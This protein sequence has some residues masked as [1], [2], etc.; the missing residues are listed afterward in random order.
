LHYFVVTDNKSF[1]KESFEIS[2]A[3]YQKLDESKNILLDALKAEDIYDQIVESYWDYKSKVNYWNIRSVSGR[4][5]DYSINHEIRSSLNRLAFNV[6][7]LGKLY[8]DLHYYEDKQNFFAFDITNDEQAK[9]AVIEQR[10]KIFSENV[11]YQIGC[12]LRSYSQHSSLPVSNFTTGIHNV[13]NTIFAS[14]KIIYGY[15]DLVGAKVPKS[16]IN[17][18]QKFDLTEILDGYVFAIAQMHAL[19]RSLIS[20]TVNK[21]KNTI[22]AIS[23][24]YYDESIFND[25]SGQVHLESGEKYYADLDWFGVVD[26]LHKKHMFTINYTE[27]SFDKQSSSVV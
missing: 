7:N 18:D 12:K 9:L 2:N 17:E 20:E 26:Y 13:N 15:R 21:A 4:N 8:L 14:F 11:H 24:S 19:N 5:L 16:I 27:I 1:E 22:S 25:C 23:K 3:T 6:L 10:Q